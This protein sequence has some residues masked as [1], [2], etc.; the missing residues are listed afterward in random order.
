LS[1][2]YSAP[3]AFYVQHNGEPTSTGRIK[4]FAEGLCTDIWLSRLDFEDEDKMRPIIFLGHG[5]GGIVIKQ[6]LLDHRDILDLTNHVLF[7]DTPHDGMDCEQWTLVT[8]RHL[9]SEAIH[10]FNYG[11]TALSELARTFTGVTDCNRHLNFSTFY[12][13]TPVMTPNGESWVCLFRIS[14]FFLQP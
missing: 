13:T 5:I 10:Q 6:A 9:T 14:F 4:T 3:D 11:S 12:C 2:G 8:G 1:F 7:F